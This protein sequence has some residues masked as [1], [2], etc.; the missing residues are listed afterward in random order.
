[1]ELPKGYIE[2]Y[3]ELGEAYIR[4]SK[5]TD[6]CKIDAVIF[7]CDGVLIDVR[8]SYDKA[9]AK[10]TTWIFEALTGRRIREDLFSSEVIFLFRRS[11]GFNNDC[12]IVYGLLM[13]LLS[14]MPLDFLKDL[15]N[16]MKAFE[17]VNGAAARIHAVR[18][19]VRAKEINIGAHDLVAELEGFTCMLDDA[20]VDSVD[21]AIL[22][23][24][25]IPEE[26][27]TTIKN[28]LYGSKRVGE[29][30]IVTVFEEIFCGPKLFKEI[31]NTGPELF[32]DLGMIENSKVIVKSETI[33]KLSSLIGGARFGISSGSRFLPVKYVLG[34]LLDIFSREATTFLDDILEIEMEY[35]SRGFLKVNLGKPNPYPLFRSAW[36]LEPFRAALFVGDSIEDA[37]AV[38]RAN[39]LDPRFIFAGV[40]AYSG[41]GGR[42]L[43]DFLKFGC[44]II[45]PSVNE[46][47]L[48]IE[49]ARRI[50][51]ERGGVL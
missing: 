21:K 17:G 31:Y 40:Y 4:E 33:N 8:E 46:I 28:F 23:L 50:K 41:A 10:T 22:S 48:V 30:I 6:I 49:E 20:G 24:R 5:L 47:P 45:S 16:M 15:A 38:E 43:R 19:S 3:S 37:L 51:L 32:Y 35:S 26:I 27:Y 14:K 1:M 18:G 36:G 12:D 7:D 44:D 2:M 39:K 29:S 42:A 34:N 9:I 13:F 11:G 25:G